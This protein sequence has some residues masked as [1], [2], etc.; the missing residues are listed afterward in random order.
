MDTTTDYESASLTDATTLAS[1]ERPR[2][3]VELRS[4][5][6]RRDDAIDVEEFD[7]D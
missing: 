1:W 3:T 6:N 7:L 5:V 2:S 4:F